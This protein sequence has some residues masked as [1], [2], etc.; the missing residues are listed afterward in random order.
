MT[1]NGQQ[2]RPLAQMGIY[3]KP[4]MMDRHKI[5]SGDKTSWTRPIYY[6]TKWPKGSIL[7]PSP[8]KTNPLALVH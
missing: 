7:P 3:S 4:R 6:M 1:R 2:V 8:Y 5:S